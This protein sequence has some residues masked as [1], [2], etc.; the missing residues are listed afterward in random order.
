MARLE[1]GIG[2]TNKELKSVLADSQT[3]VRNFSNNLQKINLKVGVDDRITKRIGDTRQSLRALASTAKEVKGLKIDFNTAGAVNN[4]KALNTQLA[5]TKKLYGDLKTV[6]SS[7]NSTRGA[8]I[9]GSGSKAALD[10]EKV[11]MAA[12]RRETVL[13]QNE[14]RRLNNE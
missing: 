5:Q 3:L 7:V 9:G 10:A 8:S 2:A 1:V 12:A 13:L 6:I 4:L 11:A 14:T